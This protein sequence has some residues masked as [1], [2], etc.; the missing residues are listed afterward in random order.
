MSTLV[1]IYTGL[2]TGPLTEFDRGIGQIL[3]AEFDRGIGK[4]LVAEFDRGSNMSD[5]E[6]SW[7][8]RLST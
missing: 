6:R 1:Q 8:M 7:W 5:L 4:I 3:V 2:F